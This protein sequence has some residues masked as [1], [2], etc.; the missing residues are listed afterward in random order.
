MIKCRYAKKTCEAGSP[1]SIVGVAQV[2]GVESCWF[3]AVG[4][5]ENQPAGP[6]VTSIGRRSNRR[7][8]IAIMANDDL[9]D[10]AEEN[11]QMIPRCVYELE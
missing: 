8:E 5:G 1:A 3:N 7:V 10:A 6:N 2:F 4:Y 11:R 9:K